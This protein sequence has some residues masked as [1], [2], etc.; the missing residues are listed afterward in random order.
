MKCLI[1]WNIHTTTYIQHLFCY[2]RK[3]R[4][5]W[6]NV[7]Q[8]ILL[9]ITN[10]YL[11]KRP[12]PHHSPE[13]TFS[14]NKHAWAMQGYSNMLIKRKIPYNCT[15]IFCLFEKK[16]YSNFWEKRNDSPSSKVL[17]L[18]SLQFCLPIYVEAIRN[19]QRQ[20]TNFDLKSHLTTKH[21]VVYHD[22]DKH[23]IY[24]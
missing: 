7:L 15:D 11:K 10:I 13:K 2:W 12:F 3:L 8:F 18:F 6:L 24:L 9:E 19:I 22:S 16:I 20:Q 5:L 21:W 1:K 14:S 4:G 17:F 23:L